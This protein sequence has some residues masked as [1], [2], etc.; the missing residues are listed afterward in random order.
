MMRFSIAL[1]E[2][3]PISSEVSLGETV[4]A[5]SK[6]SV[7]S[8]LEAWFSE[9]P[10]TG[11]LQDTEYHQLQLLIK[12]WGY[13]FHEI[14]SDLQ[15]VKGHNYEHYE[16]DLDGLRDSKRYFAF[17]IL[18]CDDYPYIYTVPVKGMETKP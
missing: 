1:P 17:V 16:N 5:H 3:P 11:S 8:L 18:S 12:K 13:R 9:V 10:G 15:L 14:R 2:L 7:A 4:A 6:Q